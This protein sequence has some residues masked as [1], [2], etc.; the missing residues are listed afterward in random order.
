MKKVLAFD[1]G[2]TNTR[3][4]LINENYEIEKKVVWPTKNSSNEVFMENCINLVKE[5]PLD[6]VVAI[7]AGVPGVVNLETGKIEFMANVGLENVEFAKILNKEFGLP[8]FIRNDAEV[9]CLCEANLGAGV[10]YKDVFFVTISTGLGGA[11]CID[12][13]NQNYPYEIGHEKFNYNGEEY[14]YEHL[15]AGS[16]VSKLAKICGVE[17]I[18]STKDMFM[19]LANKDHSVD[20]LFKE[21][22][23]VLDTFI[24]YVVDMYHPDVMCF[25]GGVMKAKDMFFKRLQDDNPDVNIVECS[26]SEDAGLVGASVLAF[27][28]LG[29]KG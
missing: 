20:V 15:C 27:Q 22:I 3:L 23:H 14:C 21:W 6:D 5:F 9:A 2:G 11:L 12:K 24:R 25:T 17:G 1:I 19:R 7:G 16:H 10:G 18:N 13:K 4:A 28:G 26:F 8:V 29:I